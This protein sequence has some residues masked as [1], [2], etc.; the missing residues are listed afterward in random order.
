MESYNLATSYLGG[1]REA[2]RRHWHCLVPGS[3]QELAQTGANEGIHGKL[4]L[5]VSC[6]GRE[7]GIGIALSLTEP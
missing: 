7:E 3:S 4:K 2:P 6:R 1:R 5:L